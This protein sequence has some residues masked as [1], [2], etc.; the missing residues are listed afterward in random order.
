M[1]YKSVFDFLKEEDDFQEVYEQCKKM[2]REIVLESYDLS[3]VKGR[4]VCEKLINK[5]ARNDSRVSKVYSKKKDNGDP[6]IPGLAE[7]LRLCQDSR[8]FLSLHR[9]Q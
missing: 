2:E 4:T 6:Y 7:L 1:E 5:F 9:E 3:F 8:L